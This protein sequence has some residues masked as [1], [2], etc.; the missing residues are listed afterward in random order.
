MAL[1]LLVQSIC[2]RLA[3]LFVTGGE[4]Q[5][6]ITCKQGRVNEAIQDNNRIAHS[7]F[8]CDLATSHAVLT[9]TNEANEMFVCD[10]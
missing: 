6:K 9:T 2:Y 8:V 10:D 4:K 7:H 1:L 5:L 3:S